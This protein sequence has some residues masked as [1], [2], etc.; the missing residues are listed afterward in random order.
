MVLEDL[1]DE[2]LETRLLAG[3]PGGAALPGRHRP[4]GPAAGRG[5][6]APGGLH[7]LHPQLRPGPVPLGADALPG[8]G[9]RGL[10]GRR[11]SPP[12]SGRWSIATST[13]IA[14]ALEAE[15]KG[16][17]HR[18]YQSRN[19][20]VLPSRRAGGDRLPGRACSVR[21]STTWW[22]S[23]ATATWSF[24]RRSSRPC[25]GATSSGSPRRVGRGSSRALPRDLRPAHGPAEAE[26]RGALRLH[27][28]G[29]EEP[30]LPA[31]HPGLAAIRARRLR[32][33]RRSVGAP[34]GA[35][36][37]R[38]GARLK[39]PSRPRPGVRAGRAGV[40]A[41]PGRLDYIPPGST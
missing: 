41:V 27:R 21:A 33:P 16:F 10:E 34:R 6:A 19:L 24:R 30:R 17:T 18:D 9:A 31:F 39:P 8:V 2:M 36:P 15:P 7:R 11:G 35:G 29:E 40:R 22:R 13:R 12:P 32:A 38:A 1:G 37:A 26:G 4:A 5:G 20:M 23:C 3:E 25:S 14:R 28:P